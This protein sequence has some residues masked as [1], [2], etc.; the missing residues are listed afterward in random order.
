MSIE[1]NG[2]NVNVTTGED[3]EYY[4]QM[5]H[6]LRA[7]GIPDG[8]GATVWSSVNESG[9]GMM[10]SDGVKSGH[11]ARFINIRGY[12]A[13]IVRMRVRIASG[14]MDSRWRRNMKQYLR[15]LERCLVICE[16]WISAGESVGPDGPASGVAGAVDETGIVSCDLGSTEEPVS[17]EELVPDFAP[18]EDPFAMEESPLA[19]ELE[20]AEDPWSI[21]DPEPVV[22]SSS[23]PS[24]NHGSGIV[25]TLFAEG[26]VPDAMMA[27]LSAKLPL[28]C[29]TFG[30][31]S[32]LSR[33]E[34][35]LRIVWLLSFRSRDNV[36]SPV[37]DGS[38]SC[39]FR[40][41]LSEEQMAEAASLW[42]GHFWCDVEDL[43]KA[44][45]LG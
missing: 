9:Y 42:D 6:M 4:F 7:A 23:N 3:G 13:Y 17:V 37:R 16:A 5:S 27:S 43:V 24:G 45:M 28:L 26:P 22:N 30:I 34:Q 38:D 21:E 33:E 39:R 31:S 15:S 8:L 10:S 11:P 1:I 2:V 32:E 40:S 19:E 20:T 29:G 12:R 36:T 35:L 41:L 25:R 18:A 14:F 44:A